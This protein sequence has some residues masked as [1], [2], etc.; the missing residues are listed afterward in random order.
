MSGGVQTYGFQGKEFK[1]R[2][3][4]KKIEEIIV[5]V[6]F[7]ILYLFFNS[8]IYDLSAFYYHSPRTVE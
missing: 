8:L 6:Y 1:E 7:L 4:G 2:F 5:S 3:K